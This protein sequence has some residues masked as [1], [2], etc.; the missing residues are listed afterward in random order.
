MHV[1]GLNLEPKTHNV[2]GHSTSAFS[3]KQSSKWTLR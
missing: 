1:F 3:V 2:I